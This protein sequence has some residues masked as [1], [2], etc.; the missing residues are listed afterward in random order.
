M[1]FLNQKIGFEAL[2]TAME[3]YLTKGSADVQLTRLSGKKSVGRSLP[4]LRVVQ[5]FR[6][7][8]RE[9][10][11]RTVHQI[12]LKK[13]WRAHSELITGIYICSHFPTA[14]STRDA[15][16]MQRK[17]VTSLISKAAGDLYELA[18]SAD[19]SRL[20]TCSEC[21]TEFEAKCESKERGRPTMIFTSW[22]SLGNCESPFTA[23][24]RSHVPAHSG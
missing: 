21:Y 6:I 22:K 8:D 5:E 16:A 17:L 11:L 1:L 14:S 23:Q 20:Y 9:M 24:Y 7:A 2:R 3:E 12:Q 19:T 18:H 13:E 4:W 10:I 15:V